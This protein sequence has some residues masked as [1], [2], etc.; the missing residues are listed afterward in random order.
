VDEKKN[1]PGDTPGNGSNEADTMAT[2]SLAKQT[3]EE[4]KSKVEAGMGT[5]KS[6]NKAQAPSI[7]SGESEHKKADDDNTKTVEEA[8]ETGNIGNS[9]STDID[10]DSG[11]N[12]ALH[13]TEK[14]EGTEPEE[15]DRVSRIQ[16]MITHRTL[17]LERIRLCKKAA[18]N[19]L[20]NQTKEGSES[21]SE[22][23]RKELTDEDEV[24]KFR[25][26][27][28]QAT[29]AA[30]R[31]RPESEAGEKRT[32]LSLRRGS[33]VGKRMN[34]ALSSLAPGSNTN[35]SAEVAS[36]QTVQSAN[37]LSSKV[38]TKAQQGGS[39]LP[40]MGM[41]NV[42]LS[43]QMIKGPQHSTIQAPKPIKPSSQTGS[44]KQQISSSADPAQ[45]VRYP[46]SKY[47]KSSNN[48]QSS[49]SRPDPMVMPLHMG[50]TVGGLPPNRLAQAKVHFPE[51]MALRERQ[52]SLQTR[53][54]I[55]L[56]AKQ[57]TMQKSVDLLSRSKRKNLPP[58]VTETQKA[59]KLP[60]RRKTHWDALLQ[61][62]SW[63]AADFIE[64][65]KWKISAARTIASGIPSQSSSVGAA[66]A[67]R[68]T[69]SAGDKNNLI[70]HKMETNDDSKEPV[71][72]KE[73]K[74]KRKSSRAKKA[75][76]IISRT[77]TIPTEEDL[78]CSRNAG[79][80]LSAMVSEL[81]NA[82]IDSGAIGDTDKFCIDAFDRFQETRLQI[83]SDK[84]EI[85]GSNS[86]DGEEKAKSGDTSG[87]DE[88]QKIKQDENDEMECDDG[89][90]DATSPEPLKELSF[91]FITQ[92]INDLQAINEKSKGRSSAKDVANALV[93]GK[94]V[95]SSEQKEM[96]DF[97]EKVWGG[98]PS[99][100]GVI[101]SGRPVSGKTFATC[102]MLWKQRTKGPQVLVC[103]PTSVVSF[104]CSI[105]LP[106]LAA[107]NSHFSYLLDSL[108]T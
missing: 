53:L 41:P 87:E 54:R 48:R 90:L 97:A 95:L 30:K 96:L 12:R 69:D 21:K 107:D 75:K 25:E 23:V 2:Q 43:N 99:S 3:R 31:S 72:S 35:S 73:K 24:A 104:F 14:S 37:A 66:Q 102:C 62:M 93:F 1:E 79:E 68:K 65:R 55:L 88:D 74:K 56:E 26:M 91:D 105:S 22:A 9:S 46:S 64:E 92:H 51:A 84:A 45:K 13:L 42:T 71:G 6:M 106:A 52:S 58:I 27:T 16:G 44:F 85:S 47:T 80:I 10:G 63:M 34:A 101:I 94:V 82:T 89:S 4:L 11:R 5:R 8:E 38:I 32:S 50:A 108:E 18:E 67:S 15:N 77:Y 103:P 70:S 7:N 33:S 57:Q 60:E 28:T 20:Q 61:E 98:K 59:P 83:L 39:S 78:K 19:R 86:S 100:K 36:A 29:Q 40:K 76:E 49:A 81:K 17:L